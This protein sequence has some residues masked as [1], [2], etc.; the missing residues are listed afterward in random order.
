[1]PSGPEG[2]DGTGS[3]EGQS[4]PVQHS[5][6]LVTR[7]GKASPEPHAWNPQSVARTARHLC[8]GGRAGRGEEPRVW[9]G[10]SGVQATNGGFNL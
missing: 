3:S 6:T 4:D 8:G 10:L 5:F 9:A 7:Q 1:M 2:R